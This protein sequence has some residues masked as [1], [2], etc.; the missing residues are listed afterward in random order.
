MTKTI[1][2]SS[3]IRRN[4]RVAYRALGDEGGLLLHL[5]TSAYHR[6]NAMGGLIWAELGDEGTIF[7]DLVGRLE[8]RVDDP[9]AG[10]AA[11]ASQFLTELRQ[12]DL[13]ALA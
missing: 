6:V 10:L 11:E 13:V 2:Q 7:E 12:R 3:H 1:D 9:P 5:D 4:P 8:G